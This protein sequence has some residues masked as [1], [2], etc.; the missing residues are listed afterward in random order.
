MNK[1]QEMKNATQEMK[2]TFQQIG[3]ILKNLSP[4]VTKNIIAYKELEIKKLVLQREY[5]MKVR[6]LHEGSTIFQ[7]LAFVIIVFMVIRLVYRTLVRF[8]DGNG[9]NDRLKCNKYHGI[10]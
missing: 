9:C 4:E 3:D 5:D 7:H 8:C 1:M 2:S 6:M 10:S